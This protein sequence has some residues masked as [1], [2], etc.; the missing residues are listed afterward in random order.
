VGANGI[1]IANE[2]TEPVQGNLIGTDVTGLIDLG[3]GFDGCGSTR[4]RTMVVVHP[5]PRNVIS[6]NTRIG[7]GSLKRI[8]QRRPEITSALT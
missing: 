2:Q 1:R 8:W 3:N 5:P 4:R 6:G 7:V